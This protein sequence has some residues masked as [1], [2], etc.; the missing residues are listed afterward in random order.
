MNKKY[1]ESINETLFNFKCDNGLEVYLLKKEDY[2]KTYALFATRFGS[3]NTKFNS[4]GKE[5]SVIDGAAHFLE[6]KMFEKEG[7][8]VM[9]LFSAQQASSNAFTSF[10]KT[11]Y[12]FSATA[13]I[14]R[15]IETLL[16]FVQDL[17]LSDESV[18]KEKPI[19]ASE[20]AMYDDDPDWQ[21]LFQSLQALYHNNP[22]KVDIAGTK[23]TVYSISK[24]DLFTYHENF[25]HPS[26][27]TLFVCGNFDIDTIAQVIENN[28]N[29]KEFKKLEIEAINVE[30]LNDIAHEFINK[31]MDV[32]DIKVN[33]SFK[34]NEYLFEPLKQDLTM[35]I[36]QDILFAK[37]SDFYQDLVKEQKV[38]DQY[39]YHYS[40][41][42]RHNYAFITFSFATD[43]KEYLIK[44]LDDFF[45]QDIKKYISE[46]EFNVVKAKYVGDFIRLFNNPESI[47]NSFIQ[48]H[49]MNFD[50]FNVLNVIDTITIDDLNTI[51]KLYNK[52]YRAITSISPKEK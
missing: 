26:N 45:A 30:E 51:T 27:M 42:V 21:S 37:S 33:Y 23:E 32:S 9:N 44:Y 10:D 4:N 22:I 1:Y 14:E 3:L 20:I 39:S 29:A 47:A 6:H 49:F 11:A 7:Y 38:S 17:E 35:S 43:D 41:D 40:Q 16:D 34:V 13:N 50:L 25:Y 46:E 19:I 24:E 8:D 2:Y 15:N 5:H 31:E 12:L 48:Y 36:L 52:D 28:Q 18:E